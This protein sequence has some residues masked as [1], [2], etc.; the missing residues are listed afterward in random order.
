MFPALEQQVRLPGARRASP[1]ADL[2]PALQ[3]E[4]ESQKDRRGYYELLTKNCRRY[5]NQMLEQLVRNYNL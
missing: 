2:L 3:A 1:A 4:L 5:S